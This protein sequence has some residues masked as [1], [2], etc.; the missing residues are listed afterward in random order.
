M[1]ANS[2]IFCKSVPKLLMN[3]FKIVTS[4]KMWAERP[5]HYQFR[6]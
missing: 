3:K 6:K 5:L 2:N 4:Q 1:L